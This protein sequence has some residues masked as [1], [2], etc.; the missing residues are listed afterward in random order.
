[1]FVGLASFS[2][3]ISNAALLI[4]SLVFA[5]QVVLIALRLAGEICKPDRSGRTLPT[6]QSGTPVFS[7]HVAIHSEPPAMVCQTLR[8]LLAQ[9]WAEADYEIIVIDNNT[10]DPA[11]WQPVAEFCDGPRNIN[12]IHRMGVGGAKAGALNIAL[13][14]TRPDATHIVTVDADYRVAPHFLSAAARALAD[15]GADYVQFPQAYDLSS[16]IAPGVDADLEEYFR[17]A[18]QLADGA[19]AVLLTGTL[20]VISHPALLAIGGW[21]MATTTEDADTGVYLCRAGYTGHFISQV[22]GKGLLPLSLRGL[23]KQRYRWA[24]GNLQTLLHHTALFATRRCGLSLPRRLAVLSQLTAWLNLSLLPAVIL[25]LCLLSGLGS[26]PIMLLSAATI[27]LSLYDLGWRLIYRGIRDGLSTRHIAS[28]LASRLALTPVAA[29]AT[30]ATLLGRRTGFAVTDKSPRTARR[31]HDISAHHVLPMVAAL[32]AL[33]T[34]LHLG[35]LI[36]AATLALI[37]PLPAALLTA[38]HLHSYRRAVDCALQ[39]DMP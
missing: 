1:M 26:L 2:V 15:T 4:T 12:F 22:V 39:K 38:R 29:L 33:P 23:E 3:F 32:L 14:L 30:L 8:T 21:S 19:E 10:A 5:L 11:L 36:G 31:G 18:A 7:I 24:S 35:P 20:C 37:L 9:D 34:A 28:A 17:T 6:W 16:E 27:L 25:I 13:S